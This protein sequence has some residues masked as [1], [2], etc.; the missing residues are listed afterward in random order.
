MTNIGPSAA[1]DYVVDTMQRKLSSL[2]SQRR[3][4]VIG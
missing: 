3:L 4:P 2:A 1:Y